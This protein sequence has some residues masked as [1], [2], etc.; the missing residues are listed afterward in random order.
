MHFTVELDRQPT[1][2]FYCE[3]VWIKTWSP[4]QWSSIC[5]RG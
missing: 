1:A 4:L 5:S 3:L 2:S